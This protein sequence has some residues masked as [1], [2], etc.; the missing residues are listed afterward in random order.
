MSDVPD[1]YRQGA[2]NLVTAVQAAQ[3]LK[4]VGAGKRC[5]AGLKALVRRFPEDAEL[6]DMYAEA[7]LAAEII[8]PDDVVNVRAQIESLRE[9]AGRQDASQRQR[10]CLVMALGNAVMLE[11]RA[12]LDD[13]EREV[14]AED[15]VPTQRALD[16]LATISMEGLPAS[17]HALRTARDGIREYVRRLFTEDPQVASIAKAAFGID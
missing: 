12:V 6:M 1:Q 10:E 2:R 15:F 3:R 17:L 5:V 11:L 8:D 14:T 13:G 9:L 4:D 7:L 16:E